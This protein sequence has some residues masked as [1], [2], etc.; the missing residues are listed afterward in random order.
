MTS[1]REHAVL[2]SGPDLAGSASDLLRREAAQGAALVA[3]DSQAMAWAVREGLP[4]A[5]MDGWLDEDDFS[6]ARRE[7]PEF[8]AAWFAPRREAFTF[9]GLCWPEFDREVLYAYWLSACTAQVLA[10]GLARRGVRRLTVFR[11]DPPRPMLYFEPADTPALYWE[12][13]FPGEVRSVV[14]PALETP[15]DSAAGGRDERPCD[16]LHGNVDLLRDRAA[17]CLNPLEVFRLRRQ[18][19]EIAGAFGGRAVIVAN[20]HLARDTGP[21]ARETGL[22]VLGLGPAGRPAEDVAGRCRR[23]FEELLEVQSEPLRGMLRGNAAHFAALFRRWTWLQATRE[24]WARAFRAAP[25]AL[26]VV[27]SLSDSE[28]QIPA[29]A[30]A[31]LG[32]PSLCLPHGVGIT[33]AVRPKSSVVPCLCQADRRVYLS[34]GI[35]EERLT[36]CLDLDTENEYAVDGAKA[37]PR[38]EGRLNVLALMTA[39]GRPGVLYPVI[40]HE[41]QARALRALAAPPP[42]LAGRLALTLKTHP[43][44]PDLEIVEAAGPKVQALLAPLDLSLA[45]ALASA[46][47]VLAVNYSGVGILHAAKAGKPLIQFWLDP[48]IGRSEPM[49]FADIYAPA[50]GMARSEGELWALMRRFLDEPGQAEAMRRRSDD[51]LR[52]LRLEE[53]RTLRDIALALAGRKEQACA[54]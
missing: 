1:M 32:V 36:G 14:L 40:R 33:R 34:S 37:L 53:S 51:F 4:C 25:P 7:A 9:D 29:E 24:Y 6:R 30:A 38:M 23:G 18:I 45:G 39:T 44:L 48:D 49:L 19:A 21:I 50:G 11:R 52:S 2:F 8:E 27:T 43:G 16:F 46:D 47:L 13:A 35:H 54:S 22:P 3:L 12:K 26:V 31:S 5:F 28:S 15:D 41:A 42:D 17:L 20:T 10:E